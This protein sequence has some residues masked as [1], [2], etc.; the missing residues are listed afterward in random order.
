[1]TQAD[2]LALVQ[3]HGLWLLAPLAVIEGPI[4]TIGAGWLARLGVFAPLWVYVICVV[5]DLVGDGIWYWVGR[6]GPKL[7]PPRW[8][9][10]L[11]MTRARRYALAGHYADRGGPTLLFGKLTHTTGLPIMLAAGMARMP[12]GSYLFWNLVGTL[13]KTAALLAVGWF[14]GQAMDSMDAWLWRATLGLGLLAVGVG[15]WLWRRKCA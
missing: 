8:W 10:R 6:L 1:M 15:F 12:F 14:L 2:I 4:V 9:M 3:A 5:G 7:L 11:G 13:P